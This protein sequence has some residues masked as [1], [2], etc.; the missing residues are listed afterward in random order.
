MWQFSADAL[1]CLEMLLGIDRF[2]KLVI[3][4]AEV[5]NYVVFF[6]YMYMDAKHL[7]MPK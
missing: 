7:I 2:R 1:G 4:S 6:D 5:D 3:A